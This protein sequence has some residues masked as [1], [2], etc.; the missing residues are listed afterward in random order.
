MVR[1]CIGGIEAQRLDCIDRLQHA[2]DLGPA[3]EPQQT[4]AAGTNIADGRAGFARRDGTQNIDP[5]NDRAEIIRGPTHETEDAA[6]READGALVAIDD[7][8]GR[9][10][11]E[12][13][14]AL[15]MLLDPDQIDI[16]ERVRRDSPS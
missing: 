2:F 7:A 6:R 12:A 11:A 5:R 16:G 1:R 15:E 9:G 14:P 10:A 4:F 8:F 13:Y 3:G